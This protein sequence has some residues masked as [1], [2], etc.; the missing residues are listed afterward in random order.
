[1]LALR[2]SEDSKSPPE[3]SDTLRQKFGATPEVIEDSAEL[4][5]RR[6]KVLETIEVNSRSGNPYGIS[7]RSHAMLTLEYRKNGHPTHRVF[8]RVVAFLKERLNQGQPPLP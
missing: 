5:W 4:C 7:A 1:M 8:R 6:G 2:F 3:K